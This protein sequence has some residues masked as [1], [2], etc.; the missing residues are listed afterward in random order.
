MSFFFPRTKILTKKRSSSSAAGYRLAALTILF[1]IISGTGSSQDAPSAILDS[2]AVIQFLSRTIAWYRETAMEQ[3]LVTEPTDVTFLQD[4]RRVAKQVVQLAFDFARQQA[5]AQAKQKRLSQAQNGVPS[6]YQS[7]VQMAE[8]ADQEVQETQA[9]IPPLQKK[10]ESASPVKRA[11]IK[12][13]IAETQS[14]VSLFS[15]RRD[16]LRSMADFVSGAS[17][18][19]VGAS[20]FRAQIEELSRSVPPAVSNS[21][22]TNAD[23]TDSQQDSAKL[24]PSTGKEAPTG[25]W[26]LTSDLIGLSRKKQ[27]LK[28]EIA[29]T[30][31]VIQNSKL[32]SE[33]LVGK[34]RVMINAGDQLAKEADTSTA[35]GLAQEKQQLDKLAVDFRATSAALLPLSKQGVVL[36]LYRRSLTSWLESARAEFK[37]DLRNLLARLAVLLIVILS[38]FIMGEV[39][40]RTIFRYVHDI[41]RRYQFLLLRKIVLWVV[42]VLIIAFTFATQLG[43]VVTFAGLITAG[44]AVALQNVIVSMV[45]YFFLIGKFGIRVGDRVQIAGVTGEVVDIGL[46]R[47]HLMEVGSGGSDSQPTGRVVAFSNSIVFQP[48]SGL[49]KQIPGTSFVWHEIDLIFAPESEYHVVRD[50]INAAVDTAF[51]DFHEKMEQQRVQMEMTL[52]SISATELKPKTRLHFTASGI[53]VNVRF[54]VELGTASEIDDRIMRELLA[55]IEKEPRLKLVGSE[56]PTVKSEA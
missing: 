7:L 48:A 4:N 5:D 39:W 2:S 44:V 54:P 38:V 46:V 49:F 47:F 20:G 21:A 34:L 24:F 32:L 18:N 16:A 43:S 41:R 19:G 28:Q 29:A 30:D 52:S 10:L 8:K 50:R 42:I 37:S 3:Q 35:A 11:E 55:A 27:V 31:G 6:E 22:I 12:T 14:E 23:Q 26:G 45:G 15:A 56:M 36:D 33:P 51:S 1:A 53:E 17:A 25:I 40:R 9:E 13:L